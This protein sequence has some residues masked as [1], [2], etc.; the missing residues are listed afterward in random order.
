MK[1]VILTLVCIAAMTA[2][3]FAQNYQLARNYNTCCLG[4]K[5]MNGYSIVG[6]NGKWGLIDRIGK[7]IIPCKYDRVNFDYYPL[8]INH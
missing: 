1:K 3:A 7:E 2:S 5:F 6:Y 8:I 4:Q